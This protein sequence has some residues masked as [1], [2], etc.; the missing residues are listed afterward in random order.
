M[1]N[2]FEVIDTRLSNIESL[3]LDIKHNSKSESKRLNQYFDINELCNYLPDKPV[4]ATVYGWVH[5]GIIPHSKGT[6]KLQFLKSDID[7]WLKAGRKKTVSE[8]NAEAHT[9]LKSK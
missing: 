3:L 9:Y 6:K 8:I 2:P 4:K 7:E 5:A 1:S